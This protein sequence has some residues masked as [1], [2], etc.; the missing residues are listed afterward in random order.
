[1]KANINMAMHI[2]QKNSLKISYSFTSTPPN[3]A[4]TFMYIVFLLSLFLFDVLLFTPPSKDEEWIIILTS[5]GTVKSIPPK[6]A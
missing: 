2:K 5:S 3:M 6:T 4:V 1:M